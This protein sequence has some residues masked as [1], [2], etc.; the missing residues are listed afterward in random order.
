MS[1]LACLQV[2][3]PDTSEYEKNISKYVGCLVGWHE[4]YLNSALFAYE[5]NSVIDWIDFFSDDWVSI[6][7]FDRFPFLAQLI[8]NSL[9]SDK[10]V[11][12]IL[13][14]VI[15][16][17]ESTEDIEVISQA[18]R[19]VLGERGNRIDNNTRTVILTYVID[20]IR[21]HK[22]YLPSFYVPETKSTTTTTNAGANNKSHK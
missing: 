22:S 14:K 8:K 7:Q 16:A 18:R 15:E 17:T 20:F 19:N 21:K 13:D 9:Y 5:T 1:E 6:L 4:S 3:F 12:S 11:I 2:I 10:G